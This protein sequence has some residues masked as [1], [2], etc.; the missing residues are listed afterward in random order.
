MP[1]KDKGIK[2][3]EWYQQLSSKDKFMIN[4]LMVCIRDCPDSLDLVADCSVENCGEC[5][6]NGLSKPIA[7]PN[8]EF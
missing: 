8:Y 5:W 1:Q 3:Q 4:N 7:K 6:I 2:F